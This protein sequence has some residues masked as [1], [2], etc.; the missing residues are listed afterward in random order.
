VT[1]IG[2]L[3]RLSSRLWA[4]TMIS[5]KPVLVPS[6]GAL[7]ADVSDPIACAASSAD[8]TVKTQRTVPLMKGWQKIRVMVCDPIF[9]IEHP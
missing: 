1:L 2:T 6:A 7:G 8:A 5:S 4:V 9:L 3:S